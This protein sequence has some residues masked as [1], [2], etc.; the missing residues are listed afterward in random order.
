MSDS[1]LK[2]PCYE[3]QHLSWS[4]LFWCFVH[5]IN[6]AC[7]SHKHA[8]WKQVYVRHFQQC[9]TVIQAGHMCWQIHA[10]CAHKHAYT[11]MLLPSQTASDGLGY[12]ILNREKTHAPGTRV[13]GSTLKCPHLILRYDKWEESSGCS[14][15][16]KS[17]RSTREVVTNVA[18]ADKLNMSLTPA[19]CTVPCKPPKTDNQ[20]ILSI[21]AING[22]LQIRDR[23]WGWLEG[24]CWLHLPLSDLITLCLRVVKLGCLAVITES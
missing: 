11:Q 8:R 14:L 22:W 20:S 15:W 16:G 7:E 13:C 18:M 4:L 6:A 21:K 23:F 1:P 24:K 12:S 2:P 5:K 19:C 9:N 10:S 3:N 17:A